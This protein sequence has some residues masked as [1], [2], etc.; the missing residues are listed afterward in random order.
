MKKI[1]LAAAF[2]AMAATTANAGNYEKTYVVEP[3]V[4]V[5]EAEASAHGHI[6]VP[7]FALIVFAAA[8]SN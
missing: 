7:L 2:A 8:L 4:V 1:A 6:L 5:K 3:K